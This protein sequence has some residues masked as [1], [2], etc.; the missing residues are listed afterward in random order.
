MITFASFTAKWPDDF[1]SLDSVD[2]DLMLPTVLREI[3]LDQWGTLEDDATEM[4]LGHKLL[5]KQPRTEAE[6]RSF[7]RTAEGY[8]VAYTEQQ[9]NLNSTKYGAEYN[10][11]LTRIKQ[12]EPTVSRLRSRYFVGQRQTIRYPVPGS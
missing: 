11:L 10:R 2:F 6:I 3:A 8:S 5:M 7:E 1:S 12:T 4:L 9:S